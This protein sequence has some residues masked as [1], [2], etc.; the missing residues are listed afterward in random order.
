VSLPHVASSAVLYSAQSLNPVHS[1]WFGSF[2]ATTIPSAQEMPGKRGCHKCDF[3]VTMGCRTMGC[4]SHI[5]DRGL[6]FSSIRPVLG[7]FSL[8]IAINIAAPNGGDFPKST[9]KCGQWYREWT[10][11]ALQKKGGQK[12]GAQKRHSPSKGIVSTLKIISQKPRGRDRDTRARKVEGPSLFVASQLTKLGLVTCRAT[13]LNFR[14]CV[15]TGILKCNGA[16]GHLSAH[17]EASCC[18]RI[19]ECASLRIW[20]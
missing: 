18:S 20:E 13:L 17:C 4:R 1:A 19:W 6:T 16:G 10:R 11:H 2:P 8:L 3:Y 14:P 12:R 5:C 15:L 7:L 9:E